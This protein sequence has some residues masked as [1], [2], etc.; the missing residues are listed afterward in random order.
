MEKESSGE[1]PETEI[2]KEKVEKYDPS[3]FELLL[4]KLK[5]L[6]DNLEAGEKKEKQIETEKR[7]VLF[8]ELEK[9]QIKIFN[10][11]LG[12]EQNPIFVKELDTI[13]KRLGEAAKFESEIKIVPIISPEVNAFVFTID[14]NKDKRTSKETD[15]SIY[16]KSQGK[17]RSIFIYTGLLRELKKYLEDK[18]QKLTQDNIAFILAH[19]LRHLLQQRMPERTLITR[20]QEEYD[21]DL[22]GIEIMGKAGFNPREAVEATEF[23]CSKAK[24]LAKYSLSHPASESRLVEISKRIA[25][26]DMPLTGISKPPSYYES[27]NETTEPYTSKLAKLIDESKNT[28]DLVDKLTESTNDLPKLLITLP[29]A[30]EALKWAVINEISQDTRFEELLIKYIYLMGLRLK[31]AIEKDKEELEK[32]KEQVKALK[33]KEIK[34]GLANKEYKNLKQL[35][36]EISQK[37]KDISNFEGINTKEV[38]N[39][40]LKSEDDL[41][42]QSWELK[43]LTGPKIDYSNQKIKEI[44]DDIFK[45]NKFVIVKYGEKHEI[46]FN[47]LPTIDWK[48]TASSWLDGEKRDPEISQIIDLG[49]KAWETG[50]KTLDQKQII[51]HSIRDKGERKKFLQSLGTK[52]LKEILSNHLTVDLEND[53]KN[54]MP[55]ELKVFIE[56][57]IEKD[58]G[59]FYKIIPELVSK[60][61]PSNLEESDRKSIIEALTPYVIP[62]RVSARFDKENAIKNL[63]TDQVKESLKALPDMIFNFNHW[64]DQNLSNYL[65]NFPDIEYTPNYEFALLS[66]QSSYSYKSKGKIEPEIIEQTKKRLRARL[67]KHSESEYIDGLD[68]L[69]QSDMPENIDEILSIIKE[70][71]K[72]HNNQDRITKIINHILEQDNFNNLTKISLLLRIWEIRD[73]SNFEIKFGTINE[74]TM[75]SK[76]E[77][78]KFLLRLSGSDI[79][80]KKKRNLLSSLYEQSVGKND[81]ESKLLLEGLL[82]YLKVKPFYYN[83]NE[84]RYYI[85]DL[86]K[87][88]EETG[89]PTDKLLDQF[90]SYNL[91]I[92]YQHLAQLVEKDVLNA[93]QLKK[94]YNNVKIGL[95]ENKERLTRI[96]E[97]FSNLTEVMDDYLDKLVFLIAISS[98]KNEDKTGAQQMLE[99]VSSYGTNSE[100]EK[101]IKDNNWEFEKIVQ[102]LP[103]GFLKNKVLY[104][105][106]Y[107]NNFNPELFEKILPHLDKEAKSRSTFL[108]GVN[109]LNLASFIEAGYDI[110]QTD[111]ETSHQSIKRYESLKKEGKLIDYSHLYLFYNEG[112]LGVL[113]RKFSQDPNYFINPDRSLEENLKTITELVPSSNFRDYLISRLFKIQLFSL[114]GKKIETDIVTLL[115]AIENKEFRARLA[116]TLEKEDIAFI[117]RL[118]LPNNDELKKINSEDLINLIR[119]VMPHIDGEENKIALG[120]WAFEIIKPKTKEEELNLLNEFFDEPSFA[121][122]YLLKN[123]MLKHSFSIDEIRNFQKLLTQNLIR[124]GKVPEVKILGLEIIR[125][126]MTELNPQKRIEYLLWLLGISDELPKE[127]KISGGIFGVGFE[128]IRK[129][130]FHLTPTEKREFLG[131]FLLYKN[132]IFEPQNETDEKNMIKFISAFYDKK[133]A[134]HNEDPL[135][136]NVLIQIFRSSIPERRHSLFCS[137]LIALQQAEAEGKKSMDFENKIKIF[138]EQSGAVGIKMGQVLSETDKVPFS[139][140]DEK[141]PEKLREILGTLK[142]GVEPFN[143]IGVVYRLDDYG[144][145]TKIKSIDKFLATASIKQAHMITTQNGKEVIKVK[146]PNIDKYIIHDKKILESVLETIRKSGKPVPRYL[147]DEVIAIIEEESNFENEANNQNLL[148]RFVSRERKG[149]RFKIPKISFASRDIMIEEFAQGKPLKTLKKENSA[150]YNEISQIVGFELLSQM[151]EKGVFHADLHDGNIF[152]NEKDRTISLIDAGAVGDAR[153]NLKEIRRLFKGIVLKKPEIAT[154]AII[155]LSEINENEKTAAFKSLNRKIEG[156]LNKNIT[157]EE[158]ISQISF[159]ILDFGVPKKNLRYFL[160]ALATGAHH[161]E[162]IFMKLQARKFN[163]I[164]KLKILSDLKST[165]LKTLTS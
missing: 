162:K 4:Q 158:M 150:L 18:G 103:N 82:R 129:Q 54:K 77:I 106:W 142:D 69:K 161:F 56:N 133:L 74:K 105:W 119:K 13:A 43:G 5:Y 60:Y 94:Y 165:I 75:L 97:N 115:D 135:L 109:E 31:D 91:L 117:D 130:F 99:K 88:A 112:A 41:W 62:P 67:E 143:T 61:I 104:E 36:R 127:L 100:L 126:E 101:Y 138:L 136:K 63:S 149:W 163:L 122:D 68:K 108:E 33:E 78:E 40:F 164:E 11:Q 125:G 131:Q 160:K 50:L 38:G 1:K 134:T 121:K 45:T 55:K 81:F 64:L 7:D 28:Q 111:Q 114:T 39:S 153:L 16:N 85:D 42:L 24:G 72:N 116:D 76:E 140:K 156:I 37:E 146:R 139:E 124:Q 107:R 14:P 47:T 35:E 2:Q 44:L 10:D 145:S 6:T 71:L 157:L 21:A 120:R 144:I 58:L 113:Q 27:I 65:D 152:V 128:S 98:F 96:A 20:R 34:E 22:G 87:L 29:L 70:E 23:L 95:K 147:V 52:F 110:E 25:D 19:E 118:D 102:F 151:F 9:E 15:E 46:D 123:F 137:L 79:P 53:K 57:E 92:D 90:L 83:A 59:A 48:K 86:P 159:E 30:R 141:M 155:D 93:T 73:F 3:R 12:L 8:S 132:G 66:L 148:S 80:T 26:P 49:I 154:T 89:I 17:S 32:I 51:S 84:E